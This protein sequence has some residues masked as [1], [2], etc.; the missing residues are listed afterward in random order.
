MR[1]IQ[2]IIGGGSTPGNSDGRERDR[3]EKIIKELRIS[4]FTTLSIIFSKIM[5][6]AFLYYSI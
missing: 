3:I 5:L 1:D 4:D 6:N 2:L